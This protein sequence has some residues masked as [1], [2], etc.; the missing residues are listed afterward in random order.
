MLAKSA[1][2]FEN[3]TRAINWG[4]PVAHALAGLAPMSEVEPN[5]CQIPLFSIVPA[6]AD[7]AFV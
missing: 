6:Y 3:F 4:H 2:T 1:D 5:Q 7:A